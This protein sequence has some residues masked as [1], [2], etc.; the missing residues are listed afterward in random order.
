MAQETPFILSLDQGTTSS[1]ALLIDKKG[2]V[3]ALSQQEFKQ[4]YPQP[5]WV[6]HHPED[7]WN[8]QSAVIK[9][10]LAKVGPSAKIVGVG[11]TNQRETTIVWERSTGKA[12]AHAIV[13]QDRR[14]ASFCEELKKHGHAD[15][16]QNKTGL[17][18]DAY[19]SA[20]KIKWILDNVP[21]AREKAHKGDLAFG[22][23]DSWLIWKLTSGK[24]HATDVSNASRTMLFNIHSCQWDQ[25]LLDLF[26]IPRS[27]LPD[28]RTCSE[29]YGT[30]SK[31]L[32][33]I[34]APIAGV[35]GDQQAAL[36]GQLCIEQGMLKNTYGTGC[37]LMLN[38]GSVPIRSRNKLLTTI[39]WKLGSTTTYAL[40]GSVFIG[41]AVVQWLRDGLGLIQNSR[42][43]EDLAAEAEDNGGVYFVPA[44]TG[45]GAPYWDP[46]AR[47]TI[48]GLT[49]GTGRQH[50]ARAALEAIAYQTKDVVE[51]MRSDAGIA[52]K[53]LRVDGGASANSK[54]MQFQAD[55]LDA[56]VVRPKCLESTAMGA[57]YFAGLA[58]GF[59]SSIQDLAE[60]WEK[61]ASYK[62]QMA[63]GERQRLYKSWQSAVQ[64][65][66][67][68]AKDSQ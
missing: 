16:I 36:F 29:I 60:L 22:T 65:A 13:W 26:E 47:G 57:A 41:G 64:H 17:V 12:I 62:S 44:F 35:A 3:A 14:T 8:S 18:I 37:F 7:I 45:M 61:D 21:G 24:V 32:F 30:I 42:D 52:L 28:V 4:I 10:V 34:D 54:L 2:Q 23:V 55:L 66:A 67:G 38:I 50:I 48:I 43:I 68:W 11:I 39:A 58:T 46:Y 25:E 19:F 31:D 5:G 63:I 33:G 15:I 20:S 9:S 6:E 40:E 59:F 1:R 56:T 27:M 49:R 51:A 53:E